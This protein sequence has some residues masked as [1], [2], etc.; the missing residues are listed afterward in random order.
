MHKRSDL[1]IRYLTF[2]FILAAPILSFIFIQTWRFIKVDHP[3][4]AA[5][6]GLTYFGMN[7][8][9]KIPPFNTYGKRGLPRQCFVY[10]VHA[11]S[12]AA[13]CLFFTHVQGNN[14]KN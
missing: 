10:V 12:L 11:A 1:I 13:F 3:H 7:P 6:L 14:L 2:Q 5:R 4:Y 8:A 9:M